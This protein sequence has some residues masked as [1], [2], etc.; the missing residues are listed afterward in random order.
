MGM[1]AG[2]L[3]FL[4]ISPTGVH[5]WLELKRG[6]AP[7][8]EA[9][10]AFI[11]QLNQCGVPWSVAR[12]Y[13]GAVRQLKVWGGRQMTVALMQRCCTDAPLRTTEKQR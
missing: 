4:L 8:T 6:A 5:H 3:D 10:E 12:D 2:M 1:R 11:D 13:E 9:Q 7:L